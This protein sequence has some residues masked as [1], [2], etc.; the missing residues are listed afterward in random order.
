MATPARPLSPHLQ[1]YRWQISNTLSIMHRLSGAF[2]GVVFAF[3]AA[4]L[5]GLAGGP[6]AYLHVMGVLRGPVGFV[7]LCGGIAAFFFHFLNGIR[8]LFWDAGFGFE[9][10]QSHMSG[11]LTLAGTVI[12][13]LIVIAWI[14]K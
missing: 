1:I 10:R 12:L 3:F 8:H 13:T 5:V 14:Y 7:A 4:W 2:L 6:D 11:W 9:K